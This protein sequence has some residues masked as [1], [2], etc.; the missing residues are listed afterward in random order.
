MTRDEPEFE[1]LRPAKILLR[2]RDCRSKLVVAP[3]L[4]SHWDRADE[5]TI[6]GGFETE[7]V[8]TPHLDFRVPF[9]ALDYYVYVPGSVT[10]I[11][12]VAHRH[13]TRELAHSESKLCTDDVEVGVLYWR[14]RDS[15]PCR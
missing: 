11:N 10:F 6:I 12:D 8:T 13:I 3:L 7:P 1:P 4:P 15:D 2:S 14:A 9:H 5:P